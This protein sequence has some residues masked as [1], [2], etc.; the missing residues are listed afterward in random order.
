M[1][2]LNYTTPAVTAEMR[3]VARFWLEEIGVDGFRLDAIGGLIEDGAIT[4]ETPATH[5]WLRGFNAY[6]ESVRPASLMVGEVWNPDAIVAPYI[7]NR[8]TDLAFEFDLAFAILAGVNAES[9]A[10]IQDA[11]RAGTSLFPPGQYGTFLANHDMARVMTQ[12]GGDVSGAGV[13]ASFLLA[14]PGVPFLYYGEEIGMA[15]EAPDEQSWRPMQWTAGP[16]AGF[17]S[18]RPWRA[19]D[20]GYPDAN[21]EVEAP[22]PGSL[23]SHYRQLLALRNEHPAL[24]SP[25]MDLV[26]SS[27]LGVFASLRSS[28]D[29]ALLVILNLTQAEVS[30]YRL[31]TSTSHLSPGR[32]RT[33]S[34]M[35]PVSFGEVEAGANGAFVD[36][37]T[38]PD[39]AAHG[40]L[41]L[42]L[43]PQ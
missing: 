40:T 18:T 13:A 27:Q 12:L 31:S 15:G 41:I 8:D 25:V 6:T 19:S 7:V 9:A 11:L 35:G 24:R 32:Y 20:V 34:L 43:T 39:L 14:L 21:V 23:L 16:Q 26:T 10:P 4:V 28:G 5:E 38:G 1:P 42:R 29:E 30:G 17:S 22:D 3:D 37:C 33:D 2:D 36:S